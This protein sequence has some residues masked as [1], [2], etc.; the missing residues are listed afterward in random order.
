MHVLAYFRQSDEEG[1]KR[2]MS[3]PL[4]ESSFLARVA[5]WDEAGKDVEALTFKDEGR[6]GGDWDR[7][8]LQ[9]VLARL[10]WADALWVYDLDRLVRH[11]DYNDLLRQLRRHHIRLFTT[12]GEIDIHS[13]AGQLTTSIRMQVGAYFRQMVSVRTM[14]NRDWRLEHGY[15]SGPAPMGYTFADEHGPGSRRVL[16][17]G[18]DAAKL[19]AM[20][21][22]LAGGR[23]QKEVSR[24]LGII[25]ASILGNR[26][27]PLYIGLVYK[28]RREHLTGQADL[29]CDTLWA[30][31]EDDDVEWIRPGRHEPLVDRETWDTVQRRFGG[32]GSRIRR[33]TH[34]LS[35]MIRCAYCDR[36]LTMQ[37]PTGKRNLV[38]RC[39][40]CRWQKSAVHLEATI[41]TALRLLTESPEL[42]R[43]M[44]AE[45]RAERP[46][47]AAAEQLA[48]LRAERQRV[49]AKLDRALDA[50]LETPTLTEGLK[51]RAL[52][53]QRQKDELDRR[54]EQAAAEVA[55][56]PTVVRDW[57]E[58]IRLVADLDIAEVWAEMSEADRRDLLRRVFARIEGNK[59]GLTFTIEGLPRS[60]LVPYVGCCEV[61]GPGLR[62][63]A[64]M[65]V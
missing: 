53:L 4:Q 41:L 42:E 27:N 64:Y 52:E 34:P 65:L 44:E 60:F 38:F 14:S 47:D 13:P 16:V 2:E 51:R 19:R 20:F 46:A 39:Q 50:I 40:P 32:R 7:P 23:S 3:I 15:W 57:R 24:T 33:G 1:H 11:E 21:S 36:S 59:E 37:K 54:V 17:P 55:S 63:N 45:A 12:E 43:D 48:A 26:T 35:G 9:D 5:A 49:M 22:M 6:S 28:H 31:A 58:Q 18:P 25:Q 10:E 30:L 61:A 56:R 8:G 62:A 29:S